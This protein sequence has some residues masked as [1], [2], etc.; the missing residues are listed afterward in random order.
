MQLKI[1]SIEDAASI[2]V[3]YEHSDQSLRSSTAISLITGR[4]FAKTGTKEL[5]TLTSWMKLSVN[6]LQ[7]LSANMRIYLGGRDIDM[8]QHDLN[9]P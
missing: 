2:R 6:T 9:C 3:Y 7:M 5:T 1:G 8:P 4:V